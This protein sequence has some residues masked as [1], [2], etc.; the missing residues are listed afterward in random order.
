MKNIKLPNFWL[1]DCTKDFKKNYKA[2][3]DC[4]DTYCCCLYP[5][6]F[7]TVYYRNELFYEGYFQTK[8]LKVINSKKRAKTVQK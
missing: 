3:S 5:A 6:W 2:I 7:V 4:I 1:T 8:D